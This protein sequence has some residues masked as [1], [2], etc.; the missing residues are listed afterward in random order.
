MSGPDGVSLV[1][2][3]G[4]YALGGNEGTHGA[5]EVGHEDD[6]EANVPEDEEEAQEGHHVRR[7]P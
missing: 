1:G 7:Q 2:D 4:G 6:Q 5:Y 3:N